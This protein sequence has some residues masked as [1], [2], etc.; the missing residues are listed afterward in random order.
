MEGGPPR[1]PQD[2]SCPAVLKITS[3]ALNLSP[4]GLSPTMAI[5]F[6]GF[7]ARYRVS[8]SFEDAGAPLDGLTTPVRHELP[9]REALQV[10]A[11]PI[12]FATTPG[13]SFDLFSSGYLDVSVP[14]LTSSSLRVQLEVS[15]VISKGFPHSGIPG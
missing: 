4:T 1:F 10:W 12:S 8:Y 7:S 15:D 6:H 13:I 3:G 11:I 5:P 14:P 9:G 2:F